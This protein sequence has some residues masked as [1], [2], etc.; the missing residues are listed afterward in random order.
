[1]V[2]RVL[3]SISTYVWRQLF[4]L[5][6][7]R[8]NAARL[9]MGHMLYLETPSCHFIGETLL[10]WSCERIPVQSSSDLAQ[11]QDSLD[12]LKRFSVGSLTF[13]PVHRT[14]TDS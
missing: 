9:T 5:E 1:M 13:T 8:F 2:I 6:S 7:L 3:S 10:C 12:S 4:F 11:I 14:F